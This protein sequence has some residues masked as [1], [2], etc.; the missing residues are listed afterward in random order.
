MI[1]QS[2][3]STHR[4]ILNKLLFVVV[5]GCNLNRWLRDLRH[6]EERSNPQRHQPVCVGDCF[7]PRND[8]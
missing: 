6:C 3:S 2:S 8:D 7:V 1:E 5:R 4:A